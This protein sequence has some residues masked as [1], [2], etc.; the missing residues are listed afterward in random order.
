MLVQLSPQAEFLEIDY[1]LRNTHMLSLD[2]HLKGTWAEGSA[3]FFVFS[4]YHKTALFPHF[5]PHR[6]HSFFKIF[7]V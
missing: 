1:L 4:H 5:S 7:L 2:T 6:N 3:V